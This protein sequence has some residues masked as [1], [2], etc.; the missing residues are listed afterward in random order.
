MNS[1]RCDAKDKCGGIGGRG[2]RGSASKRD[3]GGR[4]RE[5]KGSETV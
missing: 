5:E 4:K 1:E 3:G 2:G